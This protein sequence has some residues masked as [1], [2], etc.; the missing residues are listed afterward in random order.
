MSDDTP[1]H[2]VPLGIKCSVL[3]AQCG[4]DELRDFVAYLLFVLKCIASILYFLLWLCFFSNEEIPQD[5]KSAAPTTITT[6]VANANNNRALIIY[7]S[8]ILH[9]AFSKVHVKETETI[10]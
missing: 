9:Q 1:A 3:V 4:L 10:S 2:L 6:L 7:R 8:N 5:S